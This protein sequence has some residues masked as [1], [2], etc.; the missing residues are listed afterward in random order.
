MSRT[1]MQEQSPPSHQARVMAAY[2][3]AT[4]GGG[5]L[6][7]LIAGQ[8]VGLAGVRGAI[9]LP[10]V[11]V[12]TMSSLSLATHSILKLRSGSHG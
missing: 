5:P 3:L 8:V 7:A 11:G 9:L 2:T 1:I 6:G 10:I 4:T 12:L